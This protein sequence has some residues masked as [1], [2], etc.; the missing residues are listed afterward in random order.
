MIW[1]LL[2]YGSAILAVVFVIIPAALLVWSKSVTLGV[3]RAMQQQKEGV[4]PDGQIEGQEK[5]TGR[6]PSK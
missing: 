2:V 3:L 4:V 1:E 5:E 6:T